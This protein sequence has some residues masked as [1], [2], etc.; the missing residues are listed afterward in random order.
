MSKPM[1]VVWFSCGAASAVAAK[2][3]I[4]KYS[5]DYEIRI[6]NNPIKEED[7]DNRRFLNDVEKWIN[8][9]IEISLNKKYPDH[10][11]VTVWDS[12]KYMSGVS[13]APCTYELKKEAR[14]QWEKDNGYD[15]DSGDRL[16]LGFTS[17]ESMRAERFKIFERGELIPILID[18]GLSKNDCFRIITVA[19]IGLPRIYGLGFPNANCIGCVKSSSPKYWNLVRKWFPDVFHERA[20]Q[21]RRIG[22]KLVRVG[23]DRIFLDELSPDNQ[24]GLFDTVECGIFCEMKE[25][26]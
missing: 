10:S 7:D 26:E 20:E 9:P 13:G 8:H 6:V 25:N 23:S 15:R 21:S 19:G 11:C 18:E 17:D 22:T 2:L 3:A 14:A 5:N 24:M 1:L 16:V 12:R 4:D